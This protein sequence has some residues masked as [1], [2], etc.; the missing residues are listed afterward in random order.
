MKKL[1]ISLIFCVSCSAFS[2]VPPNDLCENAIEFFCGQGLPFSFQGSTIGA[3]DDSGVAPECWGVTTESGVW[4]VVRDPGEWI[5]Y[6]DTCAG[7][8]FDTKISV[9]KGDCSSLVCVIA[10][11]DSIVCGDDET[12][13]RIAFDTPFTGTE[14]FYVLIH[15]SNGE[16][17][18]FTVAGKCGPTAAVDD[19]IIQNFK[20]YPVP[21]QE[22]INLS[23]LDN[24]NSVTI[25]NLSGQRVITYSLGVSNISV[26]VSTLKTGVYIMK[27]FVGEQT[28]IYK[29]IKL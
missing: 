12:H 22:I 13:T 24:I 9:Y 8:D 6:L 29:I 5:I 18:T 20:Y 28:G 14:D 7:T 25:Y 21:T 10:A 16:E 2:Q 15:G 19:N 11:D 1:L 23:A 26:D 27:V 4:Y 3:T 17:G